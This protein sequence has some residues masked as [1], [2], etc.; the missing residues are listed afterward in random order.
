MAEGQLYYG[1]IE[2]YNYFEGPAMT[3]EVFGPV[4]E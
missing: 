3:S 4:A 2:D 1:L